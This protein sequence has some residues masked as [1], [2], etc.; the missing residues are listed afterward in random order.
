MPHLRAGPAR[1]RGAHALA[2]I[3]GGPGVGPRAGR[4]RA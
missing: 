2:R 1:A 3:L 4:K